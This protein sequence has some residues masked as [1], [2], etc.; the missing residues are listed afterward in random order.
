MFSNQFYYVLPTKLSNSFHYEKYITDNGGILVSNPRNCTVVSALVVEKRI[1]KHVD[2]S[3]KVVSNQYIDDLESGKCKPEEII[4]YIVYEQKVDFTDDR[5]VYLDFPHLKGEKKQLVELLDII[6]KEREFNGDHFNSLAYKNAISGIRSSTVTL[7]EAVQIKFKG[8]C[9]V[10]AKI[11]SL[12]TEF[13]DT[14]EIAEA[15]KI[16]DSERFRII[17]QFTKIW[18]VGEKTA[19]NWYNKGYKNV[20]DLL[21]ADEKLPKSIAMGIKYHHDLKPIPRALVK[22]IVEYLDDQCQWKS[23]GVSIDIVG[24]YRR[25]NELSGDIDIV[26]SHQS[27]DVCESLIDKSLNK[28]RSKG[29]LADIYTKVAKM[30]YRYDTGSKTN[31][32]DDLDKALTVIQ[33]KGQYHQIDLIACAPEQY[34]FCL[35]GWSGSATF[36][37]LIKMHAKTMGYTLS[38]SSLYNAKTKEKVPCSSEADIFHVLGLPYREPNKR[39]A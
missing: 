12:I 25:G 11:G 35:L 31:D 32:S 9:Y 17:D 15:K 10:G 6:R 37:R 38:A 30:K 24:G 20:N 5:I 36:E 13:V 1:L 7:E 27:E 16:A 3:C 34:P 18:G 21:D 2:K 14:G 26:I 4:R 22:E 29:I 39:N 33:Y 28:L 8:I 19:L 23:N